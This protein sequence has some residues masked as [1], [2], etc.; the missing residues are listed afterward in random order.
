[1]SARTHRARRRKPTKE[2]YARYLECMCRMKAAEMAEAERDSDY[3]V[4]ALV[5]DAT[6]ADM[7]SKLSRYE[8][9]LERGMYRA[10]HELQ[11]LQA[12]RSGQ[13]V[14]PPA[15]VDVDVSARQT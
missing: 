15:V 2:E 9:T 11:R 7:L 12:G 13:A 14:L 5:R 1:M 6:G 10:L 3:V 4:A 8:T